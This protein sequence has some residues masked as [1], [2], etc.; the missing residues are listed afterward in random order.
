MFLFSGCRVH[1][2]FDHKTPPVEIPDE[3]VSKDQGLGSIVKWW[4]EFKEPDLDAVVEEALAYNYDLQVAWARLVQAKDN[5]CIVSSEKY[6]TVDLGT[7]AEFR[8]E[9]NNLT[10]VHTSFMNYFLNPLL[11]Y[12]IDLWR[13]IDSRVN[14]S[15][16]NACASLEDVESTALV[17]TGAVV[18]I[19]FTIQEQ[20]SLL[21]VINYQIEVNETLLDLVEL[22]FAI[23]QSSAL[24]VYQ[25][26]LQLE[27]TKLTAI[28]VLA[29]LKTA[30]YQLNVL[31]GKAPAK[32]CHYEP[33]I[34]RIELPP[35]PFIGTPADLICR[36]PD[37]RAA[38]YRVNEAD[39]DVAAAVAD[40]Y[41]RLT[42]PSSYEFTTREWG[43]F[44]QVE[45]LR[46]FARMVTPIFD[47]SRRCCEVHRRQA[48][49]KERLSSFA[50]KFLVALREVEDAIVNEKAQ[51]DLLNQLSKSLAIAKLNLDEARLRNA[52]GLNDYLTVITAIQNLQ[53]LE[54]RIISEHK[55]LL[56][57]RSN[58]YRALGGPTL[59]G[60]PGDPCDGPPPRRSGDCEVS[61]GSP[62]EETF[63]DWD[64]NGCP[65]DEEEDDFEDYTIGESS[66]Y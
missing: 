60:Y 6:P 47:G 48:I 4:R 20:K 25:Q 52:N 9:R 51:I 24:D 62:D 46:I 32:D 30:Y 37:L 22:R 45:I 35:F 65:I 58:L 50:Q 17:L 43:D 21:E 2:V 55:T 33:G 31:L 11:N 27:E 38:H 59:V 57:T 34:T 41:P 8:D 19:W 5:V 61:S 64:E 18:D 39:Y 28:P 15:K 42:L 54:R 14:A 3:F 53:R 36:R 23:G 40:I 10:G 13:R 66:E 29:R 44:F 7:T 63:G 1:Y 49:V 12:E 16:L 56:T 26:Q